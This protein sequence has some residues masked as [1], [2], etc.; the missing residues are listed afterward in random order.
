ML[1]PFLARTHS[2]QTGLL[3]VMTRL[4][5]NFWHSLDEDTSAIVYDVLQT[6]FD[7][8]TVISIAHKLEAILSFDKVAVLSSGRL[9]E[10]DEPRKLVE[11]EESAFRRLFDLL[12]K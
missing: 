5:W 6:W 4:T 3:R 12:R 7:G 1:V 2:I 8:W 11:R 9:V 10:F